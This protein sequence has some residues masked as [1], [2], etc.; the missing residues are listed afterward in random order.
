MND[1][2]KVKDKKF[3]GPKSVKINKASVIDIARAT[4]IAVIISLIAV[5]IFG[6]VIKLTDVSDAIIM[7]VNQVIKVISVLFGCIIGFKQKEKGAIKGAVV[8]A[9]YTALS[10][11]IFW[12]ICGSPK[13]SFG[14]ADALTGVISG[15]IA[16]IIAVNVGKKQ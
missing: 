10:V 4:L 14:W 3:H 13:G 7:P 5:L 15:I 2:I 9:L 8:G 12:I 6:I 11:L 16:G 1:N